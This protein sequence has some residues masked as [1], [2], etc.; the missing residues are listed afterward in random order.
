MWTGRDSFTNNIY[1]PTS[2][3]L[4]AIST[5]NH[6]S[7]K[8]QPHIC[9]HPLK[10]SASF[11]VRDEMARQCRTK[12]R[13]YDFSTAVAA[14]AAESFVSSLLATTRWSLL[15][16]TCMRKPSQLNYKCLQLQSLPVV[17]AL[18]L[19]VRPHSQCW[20][21]MANEWQIVALVAR[22]VLEAVDVTAIVVTYLCNTS[23][24]IF[25]FK[26][27]LPQLP[28]GGRFYKRCTHWTHFFC[29]CCSWS[30]NMGKW[31][32]VSIVKHELTHTFMCFTYIYCI[33]R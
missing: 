6:W 28:L 27:Y 9:M 21:A 17:V 16:S 18:A 32:P 11:G 26:R 7:N 13:V 12:A 14:A 30:H 23:I 2:K 5:R 4:K 20:A 10:V 29:F 31:R 8:T 33:K 25:K 3:E 19:F 24:H 22:W 15:A 1:I